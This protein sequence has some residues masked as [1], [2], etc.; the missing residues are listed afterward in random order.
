MMS[1]VSIGILG[2]YSKGG[3]LP[4]D[5]LQPL[6]RDFVVFLGQLATA[7][8][9]VQALNGRDA[10]PGGGVQCVRAEPLDDVLLGELEVVVG[11]DVLLE[12]LERLVAQVAAVHQEEHSPCSGEFDE[13]V[14]KADGGVRLARTGGHLDQGAGPVLDQRPLQVL[15]CLDLGLPQTLCNEG[16]HVLDAAPERRNPLVRGGLT[17][18]AS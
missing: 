6:H 17:P 11:R 8:H 15:D 2:V 3:D 1:K 18:L 9:G 10:D 5:P 14:D 7:Q 16:W 4:E 13:P 12:F